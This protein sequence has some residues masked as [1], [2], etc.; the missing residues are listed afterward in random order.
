MQMRDLYEV[1]RVK[2]Q[3]YKRLAKEIEA[4]RIT[5]SLL[6]E[7]KGEAAAETAKAAAATATASTGPRPVPAA[8]TGSNRTWEDGATRW[9]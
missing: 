4:L 7:E 5:A 9:P 2:E 8:E 6:A 1:L 3:E